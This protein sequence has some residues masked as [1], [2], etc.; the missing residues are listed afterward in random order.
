MKQQISIGL[1]DII[2]S[3]RG[4]GFCSN[5]PL[6]KIGQD[7]E[8]WLSGPFHH[9]FKKA[10]CFAPVFLY[11]TAHTFVFLKKTWLIN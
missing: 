9:Q 2:C 6:C 1:S 11:S 10:A 7:R 4:K 3:S 5:L 8:V